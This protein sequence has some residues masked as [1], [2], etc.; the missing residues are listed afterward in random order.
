MTRVPSL[1][2]Q[3]FRGE[4]GFTLPEVLLAAM[5]ITIA[6][7]TLLAVIPYSSA[8][9]QSGSQISTATFLADQ[10]LEEA[11]LV[12]WTATPANDCLG[13]SNG[14]NAPSVHG[15]STCT[16][17]ANVYNGGQALPWA[18][19]QNATQITN[20]NGYSRT[21]RITDCGAGGGCTGITDS[22]M[23]QVTVSV[24]YTPGFSVDSTAVTSKT[25]TATMIIAQR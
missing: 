18:A 3:S 21:V 2:R 8:A 7:V 4:S 5:I 14:S 1:G 17:G 11:K 15:G 19:D 12:P 23:R 25:I 16:L 10:K 13:V 22:G 6:F 9:V 24:T 20:F